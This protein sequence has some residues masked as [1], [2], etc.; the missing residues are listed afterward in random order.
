MASRQRFAVPCVVCGTTLLLV[1]NARPHCQTDECRLG[2][3]FRCY[4]EAKSFDADGHWI[5]TGTRRNA[6][7]SGPE[8]VAVLVASAVDRG[9]N[10]LAL[11]V[12]DVADHLENGTPLDEAATYRRWRNLCGEPRCVAL[13]HHETTD[14]PR[15]PVRVRPEM[16]IR[17]KLP[18]APL[19]RRVE[20]REREE[21]ALGANPIEALQFKGS[22]GNA[23]Q[24]A[25]D[26]ARK[27]GWVTVSA[28]DQICIDYL[29]V[30][31]FEVYGDLFY[32]AGSNAA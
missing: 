6:S 24:T 17:A 10:K 3:I 23:L 30:H 9:S 31:P 18:A 15:T 4:E 7:R 20:L 28:A 1:S 12:L 26:H 2:Y 8:G 16:L 25:I 22:R 14:N 19:L 5:W 27:T 21:E 29:N 11:R 32:T 13:A